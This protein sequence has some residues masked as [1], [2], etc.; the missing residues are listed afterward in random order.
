MRF[1]LATSQDST[2]LVRTE[3]LSKDVNLEDTAPVFSPD[4]T[5]IALA[6]KYL[7]TVLWT[8]GRQLWLMQADGSQAEG[9]TDEPFYNHYDLAWMRHTHRVCALQPDCIDQPAMGG[10]R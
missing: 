9:L 10:E 5:H 2:A 6:R 7:N 1:V 4:G 8:P 3:D